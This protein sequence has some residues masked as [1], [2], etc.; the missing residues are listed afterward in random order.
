L[1]CEEP[2]DTLNIFYRS[3]GCFHHNY[4]IIQVLKKDSNYLVRYYTDVEFS[5]KDSLAFV[6]PKMNFCIS[7]NGLQ[8]IKEFERAF[9]NFQ[10][11]KV[12][13][14]TS[15]KEVIIGNRDTYYRKEDSGCQ[16]DA[17]TK[18]KL[19]LAIP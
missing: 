7:E 8:Q 17:Y 3:K 10:E 19:A 14:C 5:S 13:I 4:E 12:A 9:M 1:N 16:F 15:Y 11:S 6:E 2:T 18:L